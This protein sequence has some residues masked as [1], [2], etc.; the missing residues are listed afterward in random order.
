MIRI[1]MIAPVISVVVLLSIIG[2]AMVW[3]TIYMMSPVV[4]SV[5]LMYDLYRTGFVY[6]RHGLGAAKSVVL[7]IIIVALMLIKRRVE[8]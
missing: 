8:K 3:E 4:S 2:A 5:N 6:G 1:P 7:M